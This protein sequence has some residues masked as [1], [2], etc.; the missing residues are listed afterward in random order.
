MLN[1]NV[2]SESRTQ[3]RQNLRKF[4][5]LR[6]LPPVASTIETLQQVHFQLYGGGRTVRGYIALETLHSSC[7]CSILSHFWDHLPIS[8]VD[9]NVGYLC[10]DLRTQ[11]AISLPLSEDISTV[12]NCVLVVSIGGDAILN[13]FEYFNKRRNSLGNSLL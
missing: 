7:Y 6:S 8:V 2:V 5:C 4:R 10:A 11:T 9:F 12:E 3:I 13:F 1:R